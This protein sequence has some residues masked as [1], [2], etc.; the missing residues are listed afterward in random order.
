M[1]TIAYSRD[2]VQGMPGMLKGVV[3]RSG[4]IKHGL[5][6]L[7]YTETGVQL[8]VVTRYLCGRLMAHLVQH[9]IV[10][11]VMAI[12]RADITNHERISILTAL[13]AIGIN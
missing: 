10:L 7:Y 9:G 2:I 11:G 8:K 3:L 5:N 4:V 6:T 1:Q 13:N 12:T